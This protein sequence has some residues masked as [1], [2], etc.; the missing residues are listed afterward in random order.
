MRIAISDSTE[1]GGVTALL[2]H[3]IFNADGSATHFMHDADD[4]LSRS[5]PNVYAVCIARRES[6]H[7]RVMAGF[8]VKTTHT[9][10]DPDFVDALNNAVRAESALAN[11]VDERSS[12]FPARLG[13]S[14]A[15]PLTEDE[16]LR[17]LIAQSFK[18]GAVGT[19]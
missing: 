15:A 14:G 19:A 13:V 8:V 11:L 2:F 5:L 6:R 4:G 3:C 10:D 18:H 12:F 16:M 9:H 17:V 7:K 1:E